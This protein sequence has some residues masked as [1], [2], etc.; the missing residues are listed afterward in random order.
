MEKWVTGIRAGF[1]WKSVIKL[2]SLHNISYQTLLIEY[3]IKHD[4]QLRSA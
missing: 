4:R 1:Q 2:K 3:I